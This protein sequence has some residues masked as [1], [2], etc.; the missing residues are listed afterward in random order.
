M[1]SIKNL[2]IFNFKWLYYEHWIKHIH[3][4]NYLTIEYSGCNSKIWQGD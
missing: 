2:K 3:N 1:P 4:V